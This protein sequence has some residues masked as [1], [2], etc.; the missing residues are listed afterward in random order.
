MAPVEVVRTSA[1]LFVARNNRGAEVPIGRVGQTGSFTPVE[2]LLAAAAGC[3]AVTAEELVLRRTGEEIHFQV[4]ATDVR[5]P[6]AHELDGVRVDL[7]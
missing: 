2:L 4:D 6:G 1:H 7:D 5:P 3:G